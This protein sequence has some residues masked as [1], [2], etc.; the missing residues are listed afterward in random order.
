MP[1]CNA[2]QGMGPFPVSPGA[3]VQLSVSNPGMA[4]MKYT[5]APLTP[6]SQWFDWP[7]GTVVNSSAI[8][9]PNAAIFVSVGCLQGTATLVIGSGDQ[10]FTVPPYD[11]RSSL[12]STLAQVSTLTSMLSGMVTLVGNKSTPWYNSSWAYRAKFS[13][14]PSKVAGNLTNY[15]AFF[16]LTDPVL[17]Q[18][19]VNGG[20]DIVFTA[21]DGTTKLPHE[22]ISIY[23]FYGTGCWSWFSDPRSIYVPS[24]PG[25][26]I[27]YVSAG[28]SPSVLLRSD[29]SGIPIATFVL[30]AALE[31]DDHDNPALIRRTDGRMVAF[32]S[33]HGTDT[34]TR[35]RISTNPNDISAWDTE[36]TVTRTGN[37][38]YSNP[39][40]L[41]DGKCYLFSRILISGITYRPSFIVTSDYVSWTAD[42]NVFNVPNQRPYLKYAQKG[43]RIDCLATTG[44]PDEVNTSVYHFYAELTAGTLKWF[45]SDGTPISTAL[46]FGIND[47]TL[48]HDGGTNVSPNVKAWIWDISYNALGYPVVLFSKIPDAVNHS[49]WFASFNGKTWNAPVQI[50]PGGNQALYPAQPGYSGGIGFNGKN[51]NI[52]YA[53]FWNG[54]G[55]DL[56]KVT[57]PDNGLTWTSMV[58]IVSGTASSQTNARPYSPRGYGGLTEVVWWGGFYS[59]FS[60]SY[61]TYPCF[62]PG[63]PAGAYVNLPFV[64]SSSPSTAC[65]A[66]AGNQNATSQS[67]TSGV[68]DANYLNVYHLA[69]IPA[70]LAIKDSQGVSPGFKRAVNLPGFVQARGP[71]ST[72]ASAFTLNAWITFSTSPNMANFS[73]ASMEVV[74][75]CANTGASSHSMFAIWDFGTP[76]KAGMIARLTSSGVFQGFAMVGSN[77]TVGGVMNVSAAA[78]STIAHY[79]LSFNTTTLSAALNGVSSAASSYITGGLNLATTASVGGSIGANNSSSPFIGNIYEVRLSN[80]ERTDLWRQTV[81]NN[82]VSTATFY[83]MGSV[84]RLVAP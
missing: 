17:L 25:T 20:D 68:F 53:S 67:A 58:P 19:S 78:A 75:D 12:T 34:T 38:T 44:Q 23:Q 22:L 2:N 61:I 36:A 70:S 32:Y 8:D 81:A 16:P 24:I 18:G 14:N 39:Y 46:P 47:V 66:Y 3:S 54:L 6:Q 31:Q 83:S 10:R 1:T 11:W 43:D 30:S 5:N 26:V 35:Y 59:D 74:A 45:K 41:S 76:Q 27:G 9:Y 80:I 4:F 63:I 77:S 84:E 72:G 51:T 64:S 82:L 49:Y 52:V 55:Y 56:Y 71:T 48:I 62:Y 33:K 79:S 37:V 28:G 65:Y 7:S 57:S 21:A 50:G 73:T 29:I 15:P 60:T 42:Q 69:P 13:V 40:I